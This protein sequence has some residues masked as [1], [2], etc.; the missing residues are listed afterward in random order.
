MSRKIIVFT[1]LLVF[2]VISVSGNEP[3]HPLS[4]IHPADTNFDMS[5]GEEQYGIYNLGNLSVGGT[6]EDSQDGFIIEED[7]IGDSG[8][9]YS[10][11]YDERWNILGDVRVHEDNELITDSLQMEGN[12]NMQENNITEFFDSSC[13]AG[14]VIV[15]VDDDGGFD[16]RDAGDEFDDD[17]V[18]RSGDSM[19]GSL[20]MRGNNIGE[21]GT[22]EAV[23]GDF[24][25]DINLDR[26][27]E[28]DSDSS[29]QIV[30]GD[31]SSIE[32]HGSTTRFVNRDLRAEEDM[33]VLGDSDIE[34]TLDVEED[35]TGTSIVDSDQISS[36]AVGSQ[37]IDSDSVS[38]DELDEGDVDDRYVNRDGDTMSGS[39]GVGGN[40]IYT[41]SSGSSS[42]FSPQEGIMYTQYE[43]QATIY[44]YE[45]DGN[46]GWRFR[47]PDGNG[48]YFTVENN[49]GDGWI[50]G[51]F[52][53]GADLDL[54]N[55]D[56]ENINELNGFF[57]SSCDSGEVV[58]DVDDDG[59]F[60]C[61][62][63]GDEFDDDFVQRDGDSMTGDLEMRENDIEE[64]G[65]LEFEDN[66][67]IEGDGNHRIQIG[68]NADA[69]GFTSVAIGSHSGGVEASDR[70]A[71]ALGNRGTEAS[72]HSAVAIGREAEALG[73]RSVALGREAT[74]D[75]RG[76]VA[77]GEDAVSTSD[78]TV[79]LGGGSNDYDLEVSG[80]IDLDGTLTSGTVP[81][82]RL[83]DHTSVDTGTGL[84]GG[85]SL[86]SSRTLE[87]EDGFESGSE[88]DDRF[89]NRD[90]DTI[91]F[92]DVVDGDISIEHSSNPSLT[93]NEPSSSTNPASVRFGTED[94][95]WQTGTTSGG[96]YHISPEHTGSRS[97]FRDGSFLTVDSSGDVEV[98]QGDL[99][100]SGD[101]TGSDWDDLDIDQSDV[102]VSDLGDADDDLDMDGND[103]TRAGLTHT[104]ELLVSD[105]PDDG[106]LPA[107]DNSA[108]IEGDLSIDG[109]FIGAGAD[110]AEIMEVSDNQED[111]LEK[112]EVVVLDENLTV[113]RSQEERETGVAGVVSTDPAIVM[114]K[115]REGV[116]LALAGTAPV[117]VTTENGDI[118]PGDLLTTSSEPGKA[119]KC[120]NPVEC[121]GSII[122]KAGESATSDGTVE[123]V[124]TL[125]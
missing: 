110:L 76:S 14:E 21:V 50:R 113:K 65:R 39:L 38:V 10:I 91:D 120:E 22:L 77:I 124:I 31:E 105:S 125:S 99:D 115:D 58:F 69:S 43:D 121:Q 16:C 23:D 95:D 106:P 61:R 47:N 36:D 64:I 100:V 34:G 18:Q 89:V 41:S 25:G 37:E 114:A 102:E 53:V 98:P 68:D 73:T 92:L 8:N 118:E 109:D 35:L 71:V 3:R 80:D 86:D 4:Q 87:L 33:E 26:L 19:N 90:G 60:D 83:A 66:V 74:A 85:G 15:D 56:I 70:Y 119:M 17:F 20:D 59:S 13:A 123:M 103:I 108:Y 12:I 6:V 27:I 122:G 54:S 116:E 111:D 46:E 24:E 51:D 62:D 7:F 55:G 107:T 97:G 88:F 48:D 11:E 49:D 94:G 104:D 5:D 9:V 117:E 45:D 28:F 40:T 2:L 57:D 63:A 52:E 30:W 75:S 101:I 32:L 96:D 72:S 29:G 112:G 82:D 93:I 42:G 1:V 81:W 84:E 79:S 44:A 67:E 78:H